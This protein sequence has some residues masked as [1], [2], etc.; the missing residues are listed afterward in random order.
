MENNKT[1]S[2]ETQNNQNDG[3]LKDLGANKLFQTIVFKIDISKF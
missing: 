3:K 2:L 1:P